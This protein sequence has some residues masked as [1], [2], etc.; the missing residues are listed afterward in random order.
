MI[1]II[2]KRHAY[3]FIFL[4]FFIP[5]IVGVTLYFKVD[6]KR[7]NKLQIDLPTGD[8]FDKIIFD[9][10]KKKILQKKKF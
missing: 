1:K 6:L 10:S 4:S 5:L 9:S 3:S 7:L 2:R 8:Q